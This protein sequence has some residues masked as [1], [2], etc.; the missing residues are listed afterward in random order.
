MNAFLAE[1]EG[2]SSRVNPLAALAGSAFLCV[3]PLVSFDRVTPWIAVALG[4]PVLC[5]CLRPK[6]SVWSKLA[7]PLLA[8]SIGAGISNLLFAVPKTGTS[9]RYLGWGIF[10]ISEFSVDR[11]LAVSARTLALTVIM[12]LTTVSMSPL[13]LVRAMMQNLG[14]SPRWGFSFFAGMNIVP[15]LGTEL[16]MLKST[17]KIRLAGRRESLADSLSLPVF[18]LA[19]AIR[20]AERISVSM[21]VRGI[22][23]AGR[24]TFLVQCPWKARDTLYVALCAAVSAVVLFASLYFGFFHYDLG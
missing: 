12:T 5:L 19:G 2:V 16:E 20:K 6:L 4:I 21:T 22:E 1:C 11:C 10:A 18:L 8:V 17:R 13:D 3:P 15:A 7:L 23:T 24:R 9:P 14:L